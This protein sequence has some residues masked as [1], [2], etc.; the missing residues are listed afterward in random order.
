MQR[1]SAREILKA[2]DRGLEAAAEK[3]KS[4]SA[5]PK[6]MTR[7]DG[8]KLNAW[9]LRIVGDAHVETLRKT[10]GG[11]FARGYRGDTKLKTLLKKEGVNS[12]GQY[13]RRRGD[14]S[15]AR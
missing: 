2:F 1:M 7:G 15:G 4:D 5:A 6:K 12:L 13:L 3:A 10:Y 14:K 11:E 9:T 8:S